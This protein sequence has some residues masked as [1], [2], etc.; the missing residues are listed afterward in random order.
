MNV[1]HLTTG[2]R[3]SYGGINSVIL[4]LNKELHYCS[5]L[6]VNSTNNFSGLK[7]RLIQKLNRTISLNNTP[8]QIPQLTSLNYKVNATEKLILHIHKPQLWDVGLKLG[9]TLNAKV[10]LHAHVIDGFTGGCVLEQFCPQLSD[11]CKSCP[12]LKKGFKFLASNAYQYR[13]S[14]LES[15]KPH[16]IANSQA[17]YDAIKRSNITGDL[18]EVSVI[19][20]SVD[21]FFFHRTNNKIINK[22]IG[23]VAYSIEDKN[24]NFDDFYKAFIEL[25]KT[26]NIKALVAGNVTDTSKTNYAHPNLTFLG[27]LDQEGLRK[28]YNQITTLVITSWSESFGL[29]SV[30]AQF[31]HTSVV[32]YKNGGVPETIL[33]G[34]T[35]L[36][37]QNNS[38][39]SLVSTI[40]ESWGLNFSENSQALNYLEKYSS[41]TINQKYLKLYERLVC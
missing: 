40:V 10:I 39:K 37:C 14:L 2:G 15:Y 4:S 27:A 1:I 21:E 5:G 29:T 24:K 38:V 11:A 8:F 35:G 34:I 23:F 18:C 19:E 12:I 30:E 20:P 36:V 41:K 32:T 31:C 28:F 9:M 33:K 3:Q 6:W 22:T 17:T 26:Q 13:K 7:W 16:I 25:N